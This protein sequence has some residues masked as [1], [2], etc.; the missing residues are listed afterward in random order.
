M[1]K[2]RQT[3]HLSA[4]PATTLT[5][6]WSYPLLNPY[7]WIGEGSGEHGHRSVGG[8]GAC[9]PTF[10]SGGDAV[11]SPS[12]FPGRHF[13]TN[14]HGL[15]WIIGAIF[16]KFSQL[17]LMQIIKTVATRYQSLRL[18]C[19]KFN[20]GW[21][22]APHPAWGGYSTPSPH[23]PD[24]LTGFKD[25]LLRGGGRR[26]WRGPLFFCGST[27]MLEKCAWKRERRREEGGREERG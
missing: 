15:H 18:K 16:V 19:N 3:C 24:P 27:N 7:S 20:F 23:S 12:F 4:G 22:S 21:G 13:C 8:Q 9:P 25:L 5:V 1:V 6:L 14:A 10:W 26:E 11:L 17:I 2:W